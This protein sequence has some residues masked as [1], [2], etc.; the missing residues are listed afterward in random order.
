MVVGPSTV[1]VGGRGV[2]M[3]D[4]KDINILLQHI[5]TKQHKKSTIREN[6]KCVRKSLPVAVVSLVVVGTVVTARPVGD[7]L[8]ISCVVVDTVVCALREWVVVDGFDVVASVVVS[9]HVE[10]PVM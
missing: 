3:M 8:A 1:V 6:N 7:E 10:V 4:H 9:D 2:V 5:L